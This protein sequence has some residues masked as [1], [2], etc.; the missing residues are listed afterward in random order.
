MLAVSAQFIELRLEMCEVLVAF[1][2]FFCP[3]IPALPSFSSVYLRDKHIEHLVVNVAVAAYRF[4]RIRLTDFSDVVGSFF[5]VGVKSRAMLA[6]LSHGLVMRTE[7]GKQCG[8]VLAFKTLF[9]FLRGDYRI[10]VIGDDSSRYAT[11]F[12]QPEC[13]PAA[14]DDERCYENQVA[15]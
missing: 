8:R 13:A 3:C 12:T 11:H 9:H 1:R 10:I 14:K 5:K 15:E 2:E 7:K 4:D 6:K